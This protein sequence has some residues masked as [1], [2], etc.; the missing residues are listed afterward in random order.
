[1][2]K[3]IPASYGE[4]K[5]V[6]GEDLRSH[7]ED[8]RYR[9]TRFFRL[10]W[11]YDTL[12]DYVLPELARSGHGTVRIWS[13]GCSTGQ[14]AYST[15]IVALERLAKLSDGTVSVKVYGTDVAPASIAAARKG[16]YN[17][18]SERKEEIAK[19]P[20][21]LT[22]CGNSIAVGPDLKKIVRFAVADMFKRTVAQCDAITCL[23]LLMYYADDERAR[24]T[25]IL[26]GS[27]RTGGFLIANE[28]PDG[29]LCSAGLVTTGWRGTYR[30]KA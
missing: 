30:K 24:L 22:I 23:H 15:G 16:V 19:H 6:S 12:G 26:A 9:P 14:E 7:F 21:Y 4:R 25:E 1:M 27:L 20:R 29:V 10:K 11:V 13:A 8:F 18:L 3:K 2:A 17:L 5:L 28:V